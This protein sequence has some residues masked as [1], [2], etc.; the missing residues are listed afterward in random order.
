MDIPTAIAIGVL[1]LIALGFWI[2]SEFELSR[3]HNRGALG[4]R[5]VDRDRDRDAIATAVGLLPERPDQ[6]RAEFIDALEAR[7]EQDTR[8]GGAR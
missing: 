3:P 2:G 4:D 5:D 6:L 7:L 1:S 8:E